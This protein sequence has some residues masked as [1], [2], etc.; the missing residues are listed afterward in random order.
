VRMHAIQS[1][2]DTIVAATPLEGSDPDLKVFRGYVSILLHL[3]EVIAYLHQVLARVEDDARSAVVRSRASAL[4]DPDE[5]RRRCVL[6]GVANAIAGFEESRRVAQSVLDEYTRSRE[7]WFDLPPGRKL[8][9]R[10]AGLIVRVVLRH[11]HPVRMRMG[12]D[13]VD[14]RQLMDVILLAAGNVQATRVGFCGDERTLADLQALFEA[15]LGE[16]GFDRLPPALGY[17]LPQ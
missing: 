1:T 14:A 7:V 12:E 17:L 15:R 3:L 4:L 8:H 9:L 11:G 16:E 2:Y 10:P 5:V 6:F 13:E